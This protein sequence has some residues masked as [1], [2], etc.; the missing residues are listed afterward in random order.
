MDWDEPFQLNT[1]D[2]IW[3]KVKVKQL[4]DV[5]DNTDDTTNDNDRD[6]TDTETYDNNA[7]ESAVQ[8][9]NQTNVNLTDRVDKSYWY[10]ATVW[11]VN[12]VGDGEPTFLLINST[13]PTISPL[14][15][16][17]HLNSSIAIF[18]CKGDGQKVWILNDDQLRLP[19]PIG[20]SYNIST[21]KNSDIILNMSCLEKYNNYNI[22][23]QNGVG[24]NEQA[25]LFVQGKVYVSMDLVH[26]TNQ[27]FR[28]VTF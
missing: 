19:P 27:F 13:G 10:N 26:V 12:A 5:D 25:T 2:K 16:V 4:S 28:Q 8:T 11:A 15:L 17:C 20:E 24:E 14:H 23:C 22:T 18:R 1:S 7:S 9:T 21:E 6:V 3:Y